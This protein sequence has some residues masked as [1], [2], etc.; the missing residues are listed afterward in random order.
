MTAQRCTFLIRSGARFLPLSC[1]SG[2]AN[3]ATPPPHRPG[4]PMHG[5][6]MQPWIDNWLGGPSRR[7]HL[8]FAAQLEATFERETGPERG[9]TLALY[10]LAGC[11]AYLFW[12]LTSGLSGIAAPHRLLHAAV[13]VPAYLIMA[14]LLAR[15]VPPLL[16]ETFAS[17]LIVSSS[18]SLSL[19]YA[20]GAWPSAGLSTTGVIIS[21]MMGAQVI[22]LRFPFALISVL[23]M[24]GGQ[25]AALI[26]MPPHASDRVLQYIETI[27]VSAAIALLAN[28]RQERENRRAYLLA[29]KER[30]GRQALSL[31]NRE[32]DDLARRDALT[33]LPNRRAF[34]AWLQTKLAADSADGAPRVSLIAIDIDHFKPYNDHYGHPAGDL[35]LRQVASC[36]R[37][38]AREHTEL[39]ARIGGEEF[40]VLLTGAVPPR[41]RGAGPA[42]HRSYYY[43]MGLTE[44]GDRPAL[45]RR[46]HLLERGRALQHRAQPP[47]AVGEE[48][49]ERGRRHAARVHHHHRH[50]RHRHGPPGHEILAWCRAT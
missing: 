7:W 10:T 8:R 27:A 30:L 34:D 18:F 6:N 38:V 31:H 33:G 1:G 3:N 16:R 28:W 49:R 5:I 44:D 35:C 12:D 22:Q 46:R 25:C 40:A 37:E 29:L 39:V 41:H 23:A 26:V 45:R 24:S 2:D 9:R 20:S 42:P 47:G 43:A 50:R 15:G 14:A 32:L 48:G 36:L 4:V 19:L 17:L 13:L 21:L 11:I